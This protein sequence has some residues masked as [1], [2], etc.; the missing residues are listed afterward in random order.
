M[1]DVRHVSRFIP[2]PR[3]AVYTFDE[4]GNL[5]GFSPQS[6]FMAAELNL[7][8]CNLDDL[9]KVLEVLVPGKIYVMPHLTSQESPKEFDGLDGL[10]FNDNP[11]NGILMDKG[12]DKFG[13]FSEWENRPAWVLQ[14]G[15]FKL[16]ENKELRIS[17]VHNG[18]SSD[19]SSDE[20]D[21]VMVAEGVVDAVVSKIGK[22]LGGLAALVHDLRG[23]LR[24]KGFYLNAADFSG[25]Q[26]LLKAAYTRRITHVGTVTS[27]TIS[28]GSNFLRWVQD[29]SP[30]SYIPYTPFAACDS[31]TTAIKPNYAEVLVQAE[32]SAKLLQGLRGLDKEEF[33]LLYQA[34]HNWKV[35]EGETKNSVIID[36]QPGQDQQTVEGVVSDAKRFK[37]YMSLKGVEITVLTKTAT[38]PYGTSTRLYLRPISLA[39]GSELTKW[40]SFRYC[41]AQSGINDIEGRFVYFADNYSSAEELSI[42]KYALVGVEIGKGLPVGVEFGKHGVPAF[43]TAPT[44]LVAAYLVASIIEQ[45]VPER[46]PIRKLDLSAWRS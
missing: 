29:A 33:S 46:L 32:E 24:Y 17:V 30:D 18:Y 45:A 14:N 25:L 13:V 15:L 39:D 20:V 37:Y 19:P 42:G 9:K 5:I 27:G 22:E 4:S 11:V 41:M 28:E 38:T 23:T 34:Y 36:I 21:K 31:L 3:L 16:Q 12:R 35:R 7:Q 26:S 8:P 1:A 43:I 44:Y 2:F 40:N 10:L 6:P